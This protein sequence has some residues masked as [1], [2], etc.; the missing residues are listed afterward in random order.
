MYVN[1][2]NVYYS[3]VVHNLC[4]CF[5]I[6]RYPLF[7]FLDYPMSHY[8]FFTAKKALMNKAEELKSGPENSCDICSYASNVN[9]PSSRQWEY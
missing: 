6:F 9:I 8:F 4:G 3:N 2:C 1:L 7:V 5:V